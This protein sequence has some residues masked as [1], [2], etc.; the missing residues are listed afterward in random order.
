MGIETHVI[1]AVAALP[2]MLDSGAGLPVVMTDGTRAV[3]TE[4]RAGVWFCYDFVKASVDRLVKNF[5][6]ELVG[7]PVTAVGG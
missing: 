2:L 5:T 3:N 7:H 6:F 4:V 1:T